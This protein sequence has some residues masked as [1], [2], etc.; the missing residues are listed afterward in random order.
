MQGR[1]FHIRELVSYRNLMPLVRNA[2]T[3]SIFVNSDIL[4]IVYWKA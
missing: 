1:S 2:S 4:V 3:V